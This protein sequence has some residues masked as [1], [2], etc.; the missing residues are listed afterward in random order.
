MKKTCKVKGCGRVYSCRGYCAAHY[1]RLNTGA[2]QPDI[3]IG[4]LYPRMPC[5]VPGCHNVVRRNGLCGM[6]SGRLRLT[7]EVGPSGSKRLAAKEGTRRTY[8]GC[9]FVKCEGHP[10]ANNTGW[11]RESRM[12]LAAVV[13]RPLKTSETVIHINGDKTDA[14]AE[15]LTIKSKGRLR[16]CCRCGTPV[17]LSPSRSR[18]RVTVA[19]QACMG[20]GD[21]ARRKLSQ[22]VTNRLRQKRQA[23]ASYRSLAKEYGVCNRTALLLCAGHGGMKMNSSIKLDDWEVAEI[24]RQLSQG[25]YPSQ[26]RMLAERFGVSRS[27]IWSIKAGRTWNHVTL[28]PQHSGER[29]ESYW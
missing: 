1:E 2:V 10:R 12:V 17:A 15:N 11:V 27:A 13:G 7:G 6:H 3:P 26:A 5:K 9:M 29:Y 23:G 20:H 25:T 24:R 8:N 22:Q 4:E 16:F 21:G 18:K 14:A 28:P 19:C